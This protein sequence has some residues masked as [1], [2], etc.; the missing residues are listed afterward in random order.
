M[1]QTVA[2][3]S[4][5]HGGFHRAERVV[6]QEGC[7]VQ[8]LQ[9]GKVALRVGQYRLYQLLHSRDGAQHVW[10][11]SQQDSGEQHLRC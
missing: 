11:H 8:P 3:F 2:F 4:H 1:A 9:P 7:L 10:R 5:R 6:Q